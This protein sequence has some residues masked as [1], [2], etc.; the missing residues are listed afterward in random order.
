MNNSFTPINL[1]QKTEYLHYWH[2]MPEHSIDYSLATIWGWSNYYQLQWKFS[3]KLCWIKQGN[4]NCLWAPVGNWH[5]IDWQTI[6]MFNAGVTLI[7]VPEPL[8]L[9]IEKALPNR[10]QIIEDRG[11]WE[12]IYNSK[13]LMNL[14]GNRYHKKRNHVNSYKKKYGEPNYK[15]IDD[16]VLEDVLSL[17]DEW[18]K[19]HECTNSNALQAEN[20]AINRVLSHWSDFSGLI[21]GSLY[22]DDT[23]VAF[24]VGEMLDTNTLGVHYEKGHTGYRG[25]Y[26]T[27]NSCFVQHAG[28]NSTL[29]N[30]GQDLDEEGLRHAK[31]S[32]LPTNFL[33]KYTLNIA[34]V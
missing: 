30:R 10:V 29:V 31:T 17:Q 1:K 28:F 23:L 2:A 15:A 6:T 18:C 21:G 34:P 5:D 26:Q 14:P 11:E 24:S 8:A 33:K 4:N 7:F 12:Y 13:D 9:A 16:S 25:V 22:I 3:D 20:D 19:W 27:M 32:Y